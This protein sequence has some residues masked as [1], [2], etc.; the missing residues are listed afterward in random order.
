[1]SKAEQDDYYPP[2]FSCDGSFGRLPLV[3]NPTRDRAD[4][5]VLG[6]PY[7]GLVTFRPGARLG[8]KAIRAASTLCRN[9]SLQMDVAV[10]E[11]LRCVD[12]GDVAVNTFDFDAT[13]RSIESHVGQLLDQQI[14]PV[15]LGGDH[16]VLLPI[17]RAMSQR[18]R[19]LTLVQFDAHTDTSDESNGQ[20]YHHGTCVRRAVEEGLVAGERIFQI[21]IRGSVATGETLGFAREAGI[22]MLGMA[23]FHE[24]KLRRDF[25]D[26][27]RRTASSGPVY[28]TFDVDGVDPAFAPGTGTPVIGG[29]TSFEALQTLQ[30]LRGLNII[31]GD[32]VEVAPPYD[33]SDITALLGAGL[34]YEIAALIAVGKASR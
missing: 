7:D 21:G 32:V 30:A 17:L 5:A 23:G 8:P 14:M 4:L 25:L 18:H 10:Y 2:A 3:A 33:H 16:S 11:Q 22:H 31:G 28:I 34:A 15:C 26:Q 29:L 24:A 13:F 9:Y 20:K 27:L 1:M 12:A 19:D 6:I